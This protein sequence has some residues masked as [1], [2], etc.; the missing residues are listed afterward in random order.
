VRLAD[1]RRNGRILRRGFVGCQ[2]RRG[3]GVVSTKLA[4]GR[5]A[6]RLIAECGQAVYVTEFDQRIGIPPAVTYAQR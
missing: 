6:Q 3:V 1:S 4:A 5:G 2:S